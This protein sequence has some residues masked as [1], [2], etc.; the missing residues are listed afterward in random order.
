[1]A[2]E[3]SIPWFEETSYP[4]AMSVLTGGEP[5][6]RRDLEKLI[7]KLS[8]LNDLEDLCLTQLSQLAST[9]ANFSNV[10]AR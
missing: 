9:I 7:S 8:S 4:V 5:L 1:M 6:L 3:T 2:K 10:K